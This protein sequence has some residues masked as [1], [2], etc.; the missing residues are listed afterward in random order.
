MKLETQAAGWIVG[1]D[2]LWPGFEGH[3]PGNPLV[4]AAEMVGWAQAIAK[5]R[6]FAE[7]VIAK[8][9]FLSPVRPGEN[10]RLDV[11]EKGPALTIVITRDGVGVAEITLTR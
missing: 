5:Q 4:P 1:V 11:A 7:T 9:R 10:L 2:P 3:F 6:R 8:A